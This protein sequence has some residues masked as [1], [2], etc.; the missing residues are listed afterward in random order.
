MRLPQKLVLQLVRMKFTFWSTFSKK[1]AAKK[2]FD[3]FCT[4]QH[5]HKKALP[6]IFTEAE[7]LAF[8]FQEYDI[9][10]YRWQKGAGR[11]V[12]ILHG[13]ES[14]AANFDRYIRPLMRKGYEVL[15]FDAPGHGRSTGNRIH[16]QLYK[17]FICFLQNEFGPIQSFMAHSLGG[18]AISLAL[19]DLPHDE[20]TRVA[21]I[22]PATETTTAMDSFFRF[23]QLDDGVRKAFED[24]IL[25]IGGHPASW[26]SVARSLP[27]VKAQV[28]W[29]H[30]RNDTLTPFSDVEPM[31]EKGLPNVQFRFT[32]GLGHRRIYRDNNT[33]KAIIEFL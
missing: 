21:L 24:H 8:R 1:I 23:L 29:I 30:D 3:L 13:F 19:E 32:E 27:Q 22:A 6:K 12:L 28:L 18:L 5:R 4:P 16:A 11:R 17:E 14:T 2:A 10:G 31:V 7:Q 15:A 20:D 9:K 33:S 26:F 25:K